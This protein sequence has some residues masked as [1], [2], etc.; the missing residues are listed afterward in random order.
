MKVARDIYGSFRLTVFHPFIG[1]GTAK[2]KRGIPT[3]IDRFSIVKYL[4]LRENEK[5]GHG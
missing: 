2:R 3:V 1:Y 4:Q 5:N